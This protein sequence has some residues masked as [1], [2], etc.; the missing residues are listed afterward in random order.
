MGFGK[1][2]NETQIG[3]KHGF[4][5]LN[6]AVA[7]IFNPAIDVATADQVAWWRDIHTTTTNSM[8]VN[9]WDDIWVGQDLTNG[10]VASRPIVV[11]PSALFGGFPAYQFDG[12]ND[13]L[14]APTGQQA[15][16]RPLHDFTGAIF[17]AVLRYTGSAT[18]QTLF[19]TA[20]A[21]GTATGSHCQWNGTTEAIRWLI[22]D[23][24][25]PPVVDITTPSGTWPINTV[26]CIVVATDISASNQYEIYIKT[27]G[28]AFVLRAAGTITETPSATDPQNRIIF[29]RTLLGASFATMTM[30]E[31][32]IVKNPNA[33]KTGLLAYLAN[34]YP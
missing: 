24:V 26:N 25:N 20:A 8:G 17:W 30:A 12:I 11:D 27:A 10:T 9:P 21:N 23:G 19:Q 4:R 22:T 14:V 34:R 18:N 29:G 6:N 5:F 2:F 13:G 3:F 1:G 28:N 7:S 32:G 16:Y 15:A 31:S 33:Y